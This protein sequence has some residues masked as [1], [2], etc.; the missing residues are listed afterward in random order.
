MNLAYIIVLSVICFGMTLSANGQ[1]ETKSA[2]P[3][4]TAGPKDDKEKVS[5]GAIDADAS[6]EFTTTESGLKYRILRKS[7]EA[8]PQATDT[9][10]VHYKGWLDDKTIFDSSYQRGDKISFPLNRVVKGWTE[11][12]QL[13]GKG[14]M[15][16]LEIPSNLGYGERG[17][18]GG[19]IPPNA[20]LH[21]VVELFEIK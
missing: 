5:P 4:L 12:L 17:T 15:I 9:V 6:A 14:G 8:K 18:P 16:E 1:S 13:V 11:G 2:K 19:P 21:F 3:K 7:T 10:T 20:T